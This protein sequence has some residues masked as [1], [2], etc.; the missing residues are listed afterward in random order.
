MSRV[1]VTGGAGFIG[2]HL[3]ASLVGAGH[4][5]AVLVR[6][7]SSRERLGATL[8]TVRLVEG[9][10][11]DPNA[12][13]KELGPWRPDACAHLAWFSDPHTYLASRENLSALN[14]S[15]AFVARLLDS[16][17]RRFLITGTCAEYSP[18]DQRLTEDSP[19]GPRTL[20]AAS[21]LSLKM[22][23]TELA[24][25]GNASLAWARLFHMY[26]PFENEQRLVPAVINT[27]LK[28][29]KFAATDGT[30][31][32]DYLHVA[33]VASGLKDLV[34]AGANGTFNICSGIPVSVR[35]VIATIAEILGRSEAIQFGA[36]AHR[37]WDP[38]ILAGDNAR[39]VEQTAWAP[40]RGLR[41]GLTQTVDWWRAHKGP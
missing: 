39:L 1:L 4:D 23:A 8:A 35:E 32:R 15:L 21:K 12:V 3:V 40:S 31:L 22:L 7:S 17:C 34:G 27:L 38:P 29:A 24:A 25:E 28:G 18:S 19:T 14:A 30:Q 36:V 5:V 41:E 33:D 6:P 2:S 9:E 37:G 16:G 11:A 26:G 13:M 20:Y 10:V